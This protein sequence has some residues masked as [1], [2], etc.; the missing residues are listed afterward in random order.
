MEF[1]KIHSIPL[2][3]I[4]AVVVAS[5]KFHLES[6][7]ILFVMFS[8]QTNFFLLSFSSTSTSGAD[9]FPEQNHLS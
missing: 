1:L 4:N 7:N 5:Q 6:L 9:L 8:S 3:N 2:F